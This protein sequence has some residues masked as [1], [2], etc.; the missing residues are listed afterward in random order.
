M[1]L[2]IG[3]WGLRSFL[4]LPLVHYS[5]GILSLSQDLDSLESGLFGDSG[6]KWTR[7]LVR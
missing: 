4:R 7:H 3:D 6:L 2:G 5:V 1:A